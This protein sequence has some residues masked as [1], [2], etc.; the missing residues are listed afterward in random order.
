MPICCF[1]E[2]T[3]KLRSSLFQK[4]RCARLKNEWEKKIEFIRYV[5][6][7]LLVLHLSASLNVF[8]M[9]V[10]DILDIYISKQIHYS[11]CFVNL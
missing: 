2:R 5:H 6:A 10:L 8:P 4:R 9:H 1:H 11:T 7:V 3:G